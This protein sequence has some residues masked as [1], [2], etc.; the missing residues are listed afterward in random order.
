MWYWQIDVCSLV[1]RSTHAHTQ[2]IMYIREELLYSKHKYFQ[3]IPSHNV[4]YMILLFFPATC[5]H[6]VPQFNPIDFGRVQM[7]VFV[8]TIGIGFAERY[9]D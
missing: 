4:D 6:V 9:K 5:F 8:S 3:L 7:K 1:L 2:K